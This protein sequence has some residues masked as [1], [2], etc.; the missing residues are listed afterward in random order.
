MVQLDKFEDFYEKAMA[1]Y[2]S[3]PSRVSSPALVFHFF[4]PLFTQGI[5]QLD[6]RVEY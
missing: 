4:R 3:N 6:G 2:R 1:L 5:R